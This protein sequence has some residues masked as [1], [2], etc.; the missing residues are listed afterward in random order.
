MLNEKLEHDLPKRQFNSEKV[1]FCPTGLGFKLRPHSENDESVITMDKIPPIDL[2]KRENVLIYKDGSTRDGLKKSLEL[3]HS[4]QA[5]TKPSGDLHY[6][7]FVF[8]GTASS[9]SLPI[10]NVSSILVNLTASESILLECG[11]NTYGQL[12]RFYGP[13]KID[14]VLKSIKAV[15]ISHHHSDHHMGLVQ[16]IERRFEAAG[17]KVLVVLPPMVSKFLHSKSMCFSSLNDLNSKYNYVINRYFD[18]S[19]AKVTRLLSSVTDVQLI[20][21]SHCVYAF[22]LSITTKSGFRQVF[23]V[24]LHHFPI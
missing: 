24:K 6:P 16:L 22:G 10:R 18:D 5:T 7:E 20:P 19:K 23:F 3:L 12:L 15:F 8:L 21:V 17:N 4:K 9:V 1:I 14:Q 13:T 11:E 2:S